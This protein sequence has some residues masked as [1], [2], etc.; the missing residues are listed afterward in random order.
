MD[1]PLLESCA[2]KD[3]RGRRDALLQQIFPTP[4]F[5]YSSFQRV[6]TPTFSNALKRVV[7]KRTTLVAGPVSFLK[8]EERKSLEEERFDGQ[9]L[10]LCCFRIF[11]SS[12]SLF[13]V[14]FIKLQINSKSR[15]EIQIK[16]SLLNLKKEKKKSSNSKI[17]SSFLLSIRENFFFRLSSNI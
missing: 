13:I 5:F 7:K 10:F 1:P 6:P 2:R 12:R 8:K 15:L 16:F 11:E 4:F 3:T 17:V 9:R 14:S